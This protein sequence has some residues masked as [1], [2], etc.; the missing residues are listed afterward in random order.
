M[1]RRISILWPYERRIKTAIQHPTAVF[2]TQDDFKKKKA[3]SELD[4]LL[5]TFCYSIT[6]SMLVKYDL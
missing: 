2:T 4:N 1:S 6:E 3:F 5:M